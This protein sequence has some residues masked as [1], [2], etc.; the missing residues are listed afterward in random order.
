MRQR[1]V[2]RVLVL[3]AAIAVSSASHAQDAANFYAGKTITFIVGYGSAGSF[4]VGA[5]LIARHMAQYIPGKP[6]IVVQNMPGAGSMR[7]ANHLYNAAPKD[8][9]TLGMFGRG[10]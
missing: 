6:G 4:D 2:V 8:G 7:S 1:A 3:A 9:A 5:R 10:L